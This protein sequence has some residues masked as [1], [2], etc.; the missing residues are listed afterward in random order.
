VTWT[1]T[2]RKPAE[3]G[4]RAVCPEK[5]DS[6]PATLRAQLSEHAEDYQGERWQ[7]CPDDYFTYDH[8]IIAGGYWRR[9]EFVVQDSKGSGLLEVVW[10]EDHPGAEAD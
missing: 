5:A 3:D 1:V 7:K 8:I 10:V 9:L 6:I 2:V 4:V